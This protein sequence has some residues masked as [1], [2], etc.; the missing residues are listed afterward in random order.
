MKKPSSVSDWDPPKPSKTLAQSQVLQPNA[1]DNPDS[2]VPNNPFRQAL[3][4]SGKPAG[5]F[6]KRGRET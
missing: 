6:G 2:L 1:K 3:G 5:P 4:G